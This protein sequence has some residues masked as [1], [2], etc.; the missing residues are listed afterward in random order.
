MLEG[1]FAPMITT[2]VGLNGDNPTVLL[3]LLPGDGEKDGS[4]L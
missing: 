1:N 3:D 4:S 2:Q